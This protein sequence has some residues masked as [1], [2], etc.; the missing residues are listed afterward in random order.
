M[1]NSGPNLTDDM[2][3]LS[4]GILDSLDMLRLVAY[5]DDTFGID[6]PDQDVVYE[7]FSSS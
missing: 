6:V 4:S 5:I 3:L 1:H 2:D 7:K